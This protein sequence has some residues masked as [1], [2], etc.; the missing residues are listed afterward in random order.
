MGDPIPQTHPTKPVNPNE[1]VSP[2]FDRWKDPLK[3]LLRDREMMEH[4][5]AVSKV[6]DDSFK[7][8][9]IDI[10]LNDM[11]SRTLGSIDTSHIV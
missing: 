8:Q 7:G 2:F 9:V 11:G 6:E 4:A 3:A 10:T 1:N 5:D